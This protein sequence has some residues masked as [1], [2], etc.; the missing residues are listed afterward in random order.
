MSVLPSPLKSPMLGCH[1]EPSVG[2][3]DA[4]AVAPFIVQRVF[5]PVE[6]SRQRISVLPSP[7]K[8]PML[9]CELA[10][11]FARTVSDGVAPFISQTLFSPVLVLCQRRSLA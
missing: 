10:L 2:R 5:V 8:S 1:P 3:V 6:L 9:A 11:V 4:V 7:L